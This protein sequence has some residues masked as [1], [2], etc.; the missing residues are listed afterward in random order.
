MW[1][2]S[3][4]TITNCCA[5]RFHFRQNMLHDWIPSLNNDK[6]VK[7]QCEHNQ[8]YHLSNSNINRGQK[9]KRTNF[10]R[11]LVIF[12][13]FV[14]RNM[15]FNN[16]N[17]RFSSIHSISMGFCTTFAMRHFEFIFQRE[18][19]ERNY[20]LAIWVSFVFHVRLQGIQLTVDNHT[21]NWARFGIAL[22]WNRSSCLT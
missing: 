1:C 16:N 18:W 7:N 8:K 22:I 6:K 21:S 11:K 20:E 5:C 19:N 13:P 3:I 17:K 12:N 15:L 9:T 2:W 14:I 10:R 4:I